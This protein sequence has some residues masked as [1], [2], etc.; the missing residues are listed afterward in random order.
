MLRNPIYM[1][2]FVWDGK[3]YEGNHEPIVSRELWDKA[4]AVLDGRSANRN[5]MPKRDF[6]FSGLIRCGHCGCSM[7][8]EIKK[9]RYVYYHCSRAKGKC[10]EPYTR[11][12][13]LEE[14]FAELLDRLCFDDEVLTW[15]SQALR[16]SHGDEKQH[17]EDAIRRIQA[18]Y[19]RLQNRID[20]MYVDKL[21]GRIDTDF[22]DRKAAEWREEQRK[23]LELIR[24]HQ[25]ANQTYLDD[26]IRLLE[27]AQKAGALFRE[28]S[29]AEKR[30]GA[31]FR[32]IGLHVEGWPAHGRIP[33][34]V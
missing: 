9:S 33:P 1:G 31:R 32:T 24:E 5:R 27:L 16:V 22:F 25:D 3:T 20:A 26:G 2:E 14:R 30:P 8:A 12:E 17:H 13:V 34:T 23:C 15:V 10:P 29:P 6:A 7:V 18:D 4:Q 21:D 28:Q 11:E 19:D